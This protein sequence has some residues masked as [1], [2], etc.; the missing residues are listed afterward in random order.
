MCTFNYHFLQ[1][2]LSF[3]LQRGNVVIFKTTNPN[4]VLENLK[5]T[6]LKLDLNDMMELRKIDCKFRVWSGEMFF[7][8]KQDFVPQNIWDVKEDDAYIVTTDLNIRSLY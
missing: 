6:K 4:R 8:D 7:D 2:C 1:V 5:S 3:Q